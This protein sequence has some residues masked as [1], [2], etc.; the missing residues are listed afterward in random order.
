MTRPRWF[1]PVALVLVILG[2][3]GG[4]GA[5]RGWKE[6]VR[7][8]ETFGLWDDATTRD[9]WIAVRRKLEGKSTVLLTTSGCLEHLEPGLFVP[10]VGVFIVPGT[11]DSVDALRKAEQVREADSVLVPWT[12][13]TLQDWPMFRSGLE[14]RPLLHDGPKF[15][16][17]GRA[18][19]R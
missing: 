19:S 18:A 5:M 7:T 13:T 11:E 9:D 15:R 17:Y 1:S 3:Y 14:G 4:I 16:L 8:P 6:R 12:I 10:A 2:Q